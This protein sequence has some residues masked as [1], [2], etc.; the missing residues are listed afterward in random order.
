[1]YS[2]FSK[3]CNFFDLWKLY[4]N[5][6]RPCIF[7]RKVCIFLMQKYIFMCMHIFM[8]MHI[9]MHMNIFM[10]MYIFIH[11]G[12]KDQDGYYAENCHIFSTSDLKYTN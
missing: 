1:M 11:M 3:K 5:L 8:H 12:Q 4:E 6:Y 10:H 2:I 7:I 9:L